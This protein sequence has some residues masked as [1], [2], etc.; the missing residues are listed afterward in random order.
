MRTSAIVTL[1]LAATLL[2][3]CTAKLGLRAGI[4][5]EKTYR[6][7][8]YVV[9]KP[10]ITP[11]LFKKSSGSVNYGNRIKVLSSPLLQR[12][13]PLNEFLENSKTSAFLIIRN[14]TIL[15]EKYQQG[16]DQ[17]EKVSSF[18]VAKSFI[19]ALFGIAM[20][21]GLIKSVNDPVS[22]YITEWKDL[23]WGKVTLRQFLNHTSGI[24]YPNDLGLYYGRQNS[25]LFNSIRGLKAEPGKEF[26]YQN[27]NTELI[28][29]I[30]QR[31]YGKPLQT[32]M[33]EKLWSRIG[34][35]AELFWTV[36]SRKEPT[37]KAFCCLNAVARDYARFGRLYLHRGEFEGNQVVP[38]DWVDFSTKRDT[39]TASNKNTSWFWW[40]YPDAYNTYSAAGLFG[41]YVIVNKSKNLVIVRFGRR[42]FHLSNYW[43]LVMMDVMDQL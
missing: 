13:Q 8:D 27:G 18:S 14:D 40:H 28:A 17:N 22:D 5:S 42:S 43:M 26:E 38:S 29:L 37:V 15:Y 20:G 1:L 33:Q 39:A 41:Q 12:T 24:E 30:I 3:S 10:S 16:Y 34:T 11:F 35:E 2:G 32:Y 31:R 4:P 25:N 9:I 21:E 36:D 6:Y 7:H 19:S 23:P